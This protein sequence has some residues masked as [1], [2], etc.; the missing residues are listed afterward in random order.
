MF[1]NIS[2]LPDFTRD[3]RG[4][5][6]LINKPTLSITKNNGGK[7]NVLNIRL[8]AQIMK[9]INV[10]A[11]TKL[12]ID[13]APDMQ[14]IRLRRPVRGENGWTLSGKKDSPCTLAVTWNKGMP[15]VVAP[16]ECEFEIQGDGSLHVKA[17]HHAQ[18]NNCAR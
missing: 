8:P 11:G 12:T 14:M 2:K 5:K 16:S 1:T 3:N 13:V 9:S 10:S 17:P 18:W 4:R 6:I 7:R 15:S